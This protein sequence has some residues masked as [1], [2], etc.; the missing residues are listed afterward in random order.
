MASP[1]DMIAW[2]CGA[3][4]YTN[5][6][7]MRRECLMCRTEHPKRYFVVPGVGVLVTAGASRR[8]MRRGRG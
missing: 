7:C 8:L 5:D 6:D 3:C 1:S 2:E 4:T